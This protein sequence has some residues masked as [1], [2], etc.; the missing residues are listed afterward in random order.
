MWSQG[1]RASRE[2]LRAGKRWAKDI[3]KQ[4]AQNGGYTDAELYAIQHANELEALYQKC[5]LPMPDAIRAEIDEAKA[6]QRAIEEQMI[7]K[8]IKELNEMARKISPETKEET[9][10]VF[11]AKAAGH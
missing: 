3:R 11:F 9:K 8:K 2:T 10:D 1:G 4:I 6:H 7:R 5:G